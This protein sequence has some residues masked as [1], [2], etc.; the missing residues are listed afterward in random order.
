M[1][2]IWNGSISFGLVNIPVRMYSAANPREGID[3]DM[4][5]KDDHA[6][7][8]Y[9]RICRKDG[10]EIPWNDV[11]KG[12]EYQDGDYVVLTKKEL[13]SID[14]EKTQTIDIVQ[15][16]DQED[17]DIRYFEKP[18]YLEPVKGGDKAYALLRAALQKSGKLALAKF[19]LHER[20]H[21]AAVKPV[22]RALVLNQMRFPTDLREPGELHFPT[23]K[24][25]TAKE[26]EMALKLIQQETKPFIAEDLHDTYTE[27]LEEMIKAKTKGKRPAK[28]SKKAPSDTSAKDIMSALKASLKG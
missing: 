16:V 6:P 23:D 13:E 28:T 19:V 15:F 7:I 10:E 5:H 1:R 4:L 22:G 12:Y 18:Y 25:V 20:E 27:E 14:A 11:V 21:V 8:R 24:E 9:A 26:T 2:A 17:I 3:L